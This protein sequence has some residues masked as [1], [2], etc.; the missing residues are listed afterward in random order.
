MNSIP[1]PPKPQSVPEEALV[2]LEKWISYLRGL[3]SRVK[4]ITPENAEFDLDRWQEYAKA[5]LDT[6]VDYN[7][8]DL[9]GWPEKESV[10]FLVS[11]NSSLSK[12]NKNFGAQ[13][14]YL[15]CSSILGNEKAFGIDYFERC[16]GHS[17]D[18]TL[19]FYSLNDYSKGALSWKY[20]ASLIVKR[21]EEIEKK[22]PPLN[23]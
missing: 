2:N 22:V 18:N 8:I 10:A 14:V 17:V 23:L 13:D 16:E 6:D 3:S 11:I 1:S 7:Q 4:V 5:L 12:E 9:I 19:F 21:L 20:I 15:F